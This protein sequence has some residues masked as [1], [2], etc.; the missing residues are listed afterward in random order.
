MKK[1]KYTVIVAGRLQ[2]E[3]GVDIEKGCGFLPCSFGSDSRNARKHLMRYISYMQR[4]AAITGHCTT[5]SWVMCIVYTDY[6]TP[7]ETPISRADYTFNI[8][9]KYPVIT[10]GAYKPID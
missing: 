2:D 8:G 9:E 4:A 1:T 3:N 5:V 7:S 10:Y 6:A